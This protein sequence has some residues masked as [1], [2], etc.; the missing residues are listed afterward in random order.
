MKESLLENKEEWQNVYQDIIAR[1]LI[2][3]N[4]NN[5]PQNFKWFLSLWTPEIYNQVNK[6][7]SQNKKMY[8]RTLECSKYTGKITQWID[9]C[10]KYY[11]KLQ[12]E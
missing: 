12:L 9:T 3:Q 11:E 6:I 7:I 8:E 10:L 1:D 4:F 5:S 2:V